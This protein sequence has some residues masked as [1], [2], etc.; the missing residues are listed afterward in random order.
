MWLIIVWGTS[1]LVA[2]VLGIW[3]YAQ[4]VSDPASAP[5]RAG[6]D[7]A[8]PDWGLKLA[9]NMIENILSV[10]LPIIAVMLSSFFSASDRYRQQKIRL[11]QA[12]AAI[13]IF[14]FL[15]LINLLMA[16]V[17]IFSHSLLEGT[18]PNILGTSLAAIM[19]IIVTFSFPE[20]EEKAAPSEPGAGVP[21]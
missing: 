8:L 18:I 15:Q 2:V 21:R 20:Q 19:G 10:Y 11:I 5:I 14:S 12:I 1:V 4:L 6:I 16:V 9:K 7:T 13:G 3:R 17:F